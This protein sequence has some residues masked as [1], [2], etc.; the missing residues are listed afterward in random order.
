MNKT[1]RQ[2][3]NEAQKRCNEQ[4]GLFFAFSNEQFVKGMKKLNLDPHND[5]DK[6]ISIGSGGYLLKT[7]IDAFKQAFIKSEN[8]MKEAMKDDKFLLDALI[9]EL[10]NHEFGYTDDPESALD[11]LGFTLDDVK[12]DERLKRLFL[13]ARS[14][15]YSRD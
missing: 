7:E 10:D 14:I 11:A 15:I 9:Y 8:D 5:L 12:N 2:L 1:Y 4:E 13:K 3:K 6:I